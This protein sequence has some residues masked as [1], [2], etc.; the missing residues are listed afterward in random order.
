MREVV[1]KLGWF[2][3][4]ML[5]AV[6]ALLSLVLLKP[7]ITLQVARG[8]SYDCD[9]AY[10]RA[11][12]AYNRADK[13]YDTARR[14]EDNAHYYAEQA[15]NRMKRELSQALERIGYVLGNNREDLVTL[16]EKLD[17]V[18]RSFDDLVEEYEERK[19]EGG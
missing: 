14:A 12:E 7:L 17:V 8:S 19:A 9:D 3:R 10:Y 2:E 13:A 4:V 16:G 15:Y 1:Y 18:L 11:D 6:V 5:I